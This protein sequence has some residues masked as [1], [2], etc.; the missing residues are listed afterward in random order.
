MQKHVPS[1]S[2]YQT[3]R[4]SFGKSH[5]PRALQQLLCDGDVM[6]GWLDDSRTLVVWLLPTCCS[7]SLCT[8]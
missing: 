1:N 8:T 4:Q 7:L 5:I 2:I 6:G 3:T